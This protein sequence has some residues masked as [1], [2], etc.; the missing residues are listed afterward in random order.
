M[1]MDAN[2]KYRF[3]ALFNNA[4]N[5]IMLANNQGE[6]VD[7]ND[8]A[9]KLLGYSR[10]ELLSMHVSDIAVVAQGA[11]SARNLWKNFVDDHHPEGRTL[12]RHKAGHIIVA[13]YSAVANIQPGV[14]LSVMSD[15][16]TQVEAVVALNEAQQRLRSFS[17]RQQ[18]EFDQLR[19]DVARDL[20]DQL[21]QT[22][23]AIKLE[24]DMISLV[25]PD[26]VQHLYSLI[27]EGVTT[28]RDVSRTLR[29]PTLDLGLVAAL[30]TMAKNISKRSDVDIKVVL[31]QSLPRLGIQTETSLY[32][33]AQE[34]LTNACNHANASEIGVSMTIDNDLLRLQIWDDGCG[35]RM[36]EQSVHSGLGLMGMS[37]RANLLGAVFSIASEPGSGTKIQ[38]AIAK[39]AVGSAT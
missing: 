11:N 27:K 20:H 18:E 2:W 15:V 1:A 21:G 16:T 36:S 14:H 26:A 38:V 10:E 39:P 22:L 28:V 5:S 13:D 17:L 33:I 32:R 37:E 6:Y 3:Q 8:A 31:S 7:V 24:V 4:L 25:A 12:L 35:F 34:A 23:S 19:T 30:S 29:P 9:C